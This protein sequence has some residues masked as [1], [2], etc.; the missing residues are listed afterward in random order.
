MPVAMSRGPHR[1]LLHREP[2]LRDRGDR[3]QGR[4][5]PRYRPRWLVGDVP[6][7]GPGAT[8]ERGPLKSLTSNLYVSAVPP[9]Y[10]SNGALFTDVGTVGAWETF[11][12]VPL[13]SAVP[14][15]VPAGHVPLGSTNFAL[16]SKMN[17]LY[18]TSNGT[19]Q[20]AAGA[21]V[22]STWETF[23][24]SAMPPDAVAK[25]FAPELRFD[26]A[27]AS[28]GFPMS[29]ETFY[30]QYILGQGNSGTPPENNDPTTLPSG[31]RP[32]TTSRA[33]RTRSASA[34]GGSTGTSAT[35]AARSAPA[36]TSQT[37]STSR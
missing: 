12:L 7:G 23:G 29:A 22:P 4:P 37:G 18:V 35:P 28:S 5:H 13:G 16:R 33:A 11:Q 19:S 9:P 14:S 6:D 32:T 27:A 36:R 21:Q 3:R 2:V 20:L 24:W 30:E 8:W 25:T 10:S 1:V 34:T 31:P 15:T 17:G 26:G